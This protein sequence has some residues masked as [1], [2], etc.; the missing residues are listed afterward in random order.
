MHMQQMLKGILPLGVRCPVSFCLWLG[1][2]C[3]AMCAGQG[4]SCCWQLWPLVLILLQLAPFPV[5]DRQVTI[6]HHCDL[7][8]ASTVAFSDYCAQQAIARSLT[9]CL[10]PAC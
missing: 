6:F 8:P 1:F 5:G 7:L 9:C 10:L 4:I 2:C 3:P